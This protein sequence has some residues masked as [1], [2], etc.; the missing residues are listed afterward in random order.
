[1]PDTK[2]LG[3]RISATYDDMSKGQKRIADF[4]DKNYDKA[5]YM[6]ALRLGDSVGVSE[7]TVVRFAMD[8]GY[9]GYPQ[10]QKALQDMVRNKLTT[11]QRMEMTS[12]VSRSMV[13]RTVLRAD[14]GNLKQTIDSIN[15]EEFEMVVDEVYSARRI[16]ILGARSSAPLAQFMGY[17]MNFLLD[18]VYVVTSGINDIMEQLVHIEREDVLISISFPRYSKRTVEGVH[19]AKEKG[20]KIVAITDSGASPL[21]EYADHVLVA[22]SNIA[23]FVDSLVAPFSIVNAFIVSIGLRKRQE[24]SENFMELE[25]IWDEYNVYV[26][27]GKSGL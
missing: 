15:A 11:L 14:M 27:K 21:N 22:H 24:A 20:A 2:E 1:L 16:Y 5:A 13:L 10:L 6:T 7:S 9:T 23:S 26:D 19:F 25:R 12:E 17:Y 4:I 3:L 8:L 18:N